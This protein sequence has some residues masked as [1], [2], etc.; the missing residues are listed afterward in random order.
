MKI[1]IVV[2]V[3]NDV[4]VG[5]SL[6]SILSQQHGHELELIVVDSGSTDGTLE[7]LER[8]RN[9]I[10]VLIS[11]PDR[12]IFDGINKGIRLAT[13]DIIGILGADDYYSDRSVLSDVAD[14]I[15]ATGADGCYG[16]MVYVDD[17]G[18]TVR[19]WKAG[20]D[21]RFKW[22][23]GWQPPHFTVFFQS[24]VYDS[25]G[26]YDLDFPISADYEFLMRVM[27]INRNRLEYTDR[28][29]LKM[30]LGGNSNRSI[31]NI[32][33][34]RR[35]VAGAWKKNGLRGGIWVSCLKPVSKLIQYVRSPPAGI[36]NS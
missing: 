15:K 29:L 13:G 2:P 36:C 6:E 18:N 31:G 5:R 17:N 34:A 25:L 4:R 12:G 21:F 33:K 7:V 30:T 11:E 9:K 22:Y 24:S 19:Y 14:A 32:I 3:F 20:P 23:L 27:F 26:L 8:Y 10:S 35:E 16:D 1:S 28:V